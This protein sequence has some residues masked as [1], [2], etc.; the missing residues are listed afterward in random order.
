[1]TAAKWA[2]QSAKFQTFNCSR[3][4]SPILYF[5]RLLLL[6]VYKISAKKSIED[7]CLMTLK[8]DAKFEEKLIYCFKNEKNL[9]SFNLSTWNS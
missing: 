4:I 8:I 1:M 9:V 2:H 6:K 5:D 7:L 3:E